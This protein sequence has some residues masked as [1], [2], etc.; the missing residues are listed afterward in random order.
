MGFIASV[1]LAAS[2]AYG[3]SIGSLAGSPLDFAA[4]RL[5]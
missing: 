4:S 1:D 5:A 3:A 2:I